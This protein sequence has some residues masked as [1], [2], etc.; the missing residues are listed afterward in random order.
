MAKYTIDHSCGHEQTHDLIGRH[1]DRDRKI[2]WLETT[3]CAD[4]Y[5]AK[6]EREREEQAQKAAQDAQ[7]VGLPD[8]TGTE[9]QIR[10]ALQ[11][12]SEF[13][14]PF[15]KPLPEGGIRFHHV[16]R[17]TNEFRGTDEFSTRLREAAALC[18]ESAASLSKE[19]KEASE[20]EREERILSGVVSVATAFAASRTS[21]H[22]WIDHR[23]DLFSRFLTDRRAELA[24]VLEAAL[25]GTS[26]AEVL[27]AQARVQVEKELAR[28]Q[29]NAAREEATLYPQ[30]ETS[31]LPVEVRLDEGAVVVRTPYGAENAV[32]RLK[33]LGFKWDRP[34][35]RKSTT[36]FGD[37]EHRAA[38]VVHD[39]L[40]L[41]YPVVC[42]S[43][44][45]RER[46]LSG[47]YELE[48]TRFVNTIKKDAAQHGGWFAIGWSKEDDLYAEAK[49][50]KGARY[51][52]PFVVVPPKNW[53]QVADFAERNGCKILGTAQKLIEAQRAAEEEKIRVEVALAP[54][55]GEMPAP[56][57]AT[58]APLAVPVEVEVPSAL[59]D[60]ETENE[61]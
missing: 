25:R 35:W 54:E 28:E 60:E 20:Q 24:A 47:S 61:N 5:R 37:R 57:P 43:A 7:E 4:C 6:I 41:G 42:Q 21:A 56:L 3:L 10:W 27:E 55:P 39:L 13:L 31:P 16:S 8:L 53:E 38:Q 30:S 33:E 45:V 18:R 48:P 11:L 1:K 12:R 19:E 40:E 50:L 17:V 58:P 22:W 34:V 26:E 36:R 32:A 59:Q 15:E 29:Q 14:A 23:Y 52:K 9:K 49:R 46:A 2:A 51:D 44:N